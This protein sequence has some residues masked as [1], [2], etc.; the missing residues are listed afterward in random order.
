MFIYN[1]K[2]NSFSG[3]T[4]AW[5]LQ[6]KVRIYYDS[7]TTSYKFTCYPFYQT[8]NNVYENTTSASITITNINKWNYIICAV[9][10]DALSY[11]L[12]TD[13]QA[14]TTNTYINT[15][16]KPTKD[17]TSNNSKIVITDETT[18]DYGVLFFSQ[19][20]LWKEAYINAGF[21]SRVSIQTKSLFTTLVSLFDPL[22]IPADSTSQKFSEIVTPPAAANQVVITYQSTLGVNVVNDSLYSKINLCSENGQYY[23]SISNSCI[24]KDLYFKIRIHQFIKAK[25]YELSK[26]CNSTCCK[27]YM[28]CLL[29][30]VHH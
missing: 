8:T 29:R 27:Y 10:F 13:T 2:G 26:Y 17:P 30:K 14:A 3:L 21:L 9:D 20:R 11:Y 7:A 25:R 1:Y 6:T 16:A 12:T 23:E 15:V 24:S 18:I 19:I 4:I 22:Y 5:D 28:E